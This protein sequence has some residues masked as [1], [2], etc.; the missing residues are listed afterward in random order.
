MQHQTTK[1]SP[2]APTHPL[3]RLRETGILTRAIL[4]VLLTLTLFEAANWAMDI[5]NA[6]AKQIAS[7]FDTIRKDT[8]PHHEARKIDVLNV[9]PVIE[10]LEEKPKQRK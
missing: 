9:G 7:N 2:F 5:T 4:I 8:T 3:S 6:N 1:Q 10:A